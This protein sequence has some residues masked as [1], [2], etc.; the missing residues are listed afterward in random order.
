MPRARRA[1]RTAGARAPARRSP[2]GDWTDLSCFTEGPVPPHRPLRQN[3]AFAPCPHGD[4]AGLARHHGCREVDERIPVGLDG[5]RVHEARADLDE[6]IGHGCTARQE[7]T[8]LSE[9]AQPRAEIESE[10]SGERHRKVG[11]ATRVDGQLGG[12]PGYP[13]C[14]RRCMCAAMAATIVSAS[15]P[16][17]S[18]TSP[19]A[20]CPNAMTAPGPGSSGMA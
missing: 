8:S 1:S 9:L 4:R 7:Q 6:C 15:A 11:V 17:P 3:P 13:R 10:Q 5:R 16:L 14:S 18:R 20:S 12:L 2:C 19:T